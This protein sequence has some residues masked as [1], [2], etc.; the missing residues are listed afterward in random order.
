MTGRNN[1]KKLW[2]K[3]P[4]AA[5][6]RAEA[7]VL[8]AELEMELRELRKSRGLTQAQVAEALDVE[9][10]AVAKLE[11]RK[12]MR[13]GTLQEL[14]EAMGGKLE[15]IARFPDATVKIAD[16]EEA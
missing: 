5:R 9:Q 6:A 14:I 3:L 16:F 8:V 2:D 15:L 7:K 4:E 12:D 13:I 1:F 11:N 10:P